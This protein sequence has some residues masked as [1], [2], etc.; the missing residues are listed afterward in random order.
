MNNI[1]HL[2]VENN[3]GKPKMLLKHTVK[4]FIKQVRSFDKEVIG[5]VPSQRLSF[6]DRLN[7]NKVL[8][9]IEDAYR[10]GFMEGYDRSIHDTG[11]IINDL[12][13]NELI[14]EV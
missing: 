10:R 14:K 9:T 8:K 12:I 2:G 6:I 13:A 7:S 4:E 1:I 3:K 5:I 11:V